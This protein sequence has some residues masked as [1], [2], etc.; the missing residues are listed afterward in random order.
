M[1]STSGTTDCEAY[2][3]KLQSMGSN[4]PGRLFLS[5]AAG[6]IGN[7]NYYFD[8][9]RSTPFV[10]Y[11]NLGSGAMSGVLAANPSASVTYTNVTPD[12]A[13]ANHITNG[14][15]V[16]GYLCW[17]TH[18]ILSTNYATNNSLVW[19]GN[20]GWWIIRTVESF[21][22]DRTAN[23][24]GNFLSW[25]SPNA[26]GGMNYGNTP[27]GAVSYVDEPYVPG[28]LDQVYFGLWESGKAFASCAWNS[29]ANP[30]PQNVGDPFVSK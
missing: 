4:L 17:G 3:N 15:N 6:G 1:N 25:F 22:G 18:S 10:S 11:P 12:S 13:L 20:N 21:N 24:F 8:D 28:T 26:F 27:V 2:I 29:T 14:L 16:A 9:S 5:G 30:Y 7:N 19:N 23:G